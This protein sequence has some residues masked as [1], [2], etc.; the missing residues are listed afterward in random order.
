MERA[1]KAFLTCVSPQLMSTAGTGASSA[2]PGNFCFIVFP[3]SL[4]GIFLSV[5]H[6]SEQN[7]IEFCL[8]L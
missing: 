2:L 3:L 6:F 7:T 4:N 1:V 5:Y 8:F